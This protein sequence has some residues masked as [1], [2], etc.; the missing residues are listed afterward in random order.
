V[1]RAE[2]VGCTNRIVLDVSKTG[3]VEEIYTIV[4]YVLCV[5]DDT[6]TMIEVLD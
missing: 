6:T 3:T 5:E 2:E 1:T 4:L